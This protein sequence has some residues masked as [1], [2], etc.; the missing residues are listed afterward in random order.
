MAQPQRP[1]STPVCM[2]TAVIMSEQS[3]GITSCGLRLHLLVR[4]A[5]L[6]SQVQC[7]QQG[8]REVVEV[9][10]R[11]DSVHNIQI[12]ERHKQALVLVL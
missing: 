10:A 1:Y 4:K 5:K 9:V 8:Q 12:P 7:K 11:V 3:L 2:Q 6:L